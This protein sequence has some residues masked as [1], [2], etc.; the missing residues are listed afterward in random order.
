MMEMELWSLEPIRDKTFE[1]I[2][3]SGEENRTKSIVVEEVEVTL[4]G[5]D[6]T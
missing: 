6:M 3:D 2:R 5:W 4:V 1:E